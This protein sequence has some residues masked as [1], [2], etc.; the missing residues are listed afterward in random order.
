MNS[1]L[2]IKTPL[3]G[4]FIFI[5]AGWSGLGCTAELMG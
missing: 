3:K 1:Y 5:G 4:D 2:K